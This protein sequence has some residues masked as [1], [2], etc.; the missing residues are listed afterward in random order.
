[1]QT[2]Y[3]LPEKVSQ[4]MHSNVTELLCFRYSLFGYLGAFVFDFDK[5]F[6]YDNFKYK[7]F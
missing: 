4:C 3:T 5:N 7:M 6:C 1:M 2:N